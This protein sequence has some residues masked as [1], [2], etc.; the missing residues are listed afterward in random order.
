[1]T[2][3]VTL[4]SVSVTKGIVDS[5]VSSNKVKMLILKWGQG[6]TQYIVWSSDVK[7]LCPMRKKN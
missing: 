3:A 5:I 7:R 6:D 1:M 4:S 2:A